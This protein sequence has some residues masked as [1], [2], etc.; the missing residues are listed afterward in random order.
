MAIM[1][2]TISLPFMIGMART[3]L[4]LYSVSSSTKSLKWGLCEERERERDKEFNW[5][6]LTCSLPLHPS[7]LPNSTL[8]NTLLLSTNA[9]SK[10]FPLSTNSRLSL[11]HSTYCSSC[12]AGVINC[13]PLGVKKRKSGSLT[14]KKKQKPAESD[15][16]GTGIGVTV[17]FWV[18]QGVSFRCDLVSWFG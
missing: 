1:T 13:A 5:I 14:A 9:A 3:F 11:L 15:P 10:G 12:T 17:L 4:V 7:K 6:Q 16:R 18:K 8:M 2:A